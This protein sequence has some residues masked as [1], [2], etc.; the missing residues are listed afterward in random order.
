MRSIDDT[1][2][3]GNHR[4]GKVRQHN[5][6]QSL[7]SLP[8]L[9]VVRNGI[10]N[11][12]QSKGVRRKRAGTKAHKLSGSEIEK[13]KESGWPKAATQILHAMHYLLSQATVQV[14]AFAISH[15]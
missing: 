7:C 12:K 5:V 15:E 4:G 3:A 2:V 8:D 11:A 14:L 13:G 10:M 6:Q 1:R 9:R